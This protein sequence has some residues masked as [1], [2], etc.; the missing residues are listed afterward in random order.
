[1]ITAAGGTLIG[2]D[3]VKL[4]LPADALVADREFQISKNATGAPNLPEGSGGTD[5]D[6]RDHSAYT[7][8]ATP[9][10]LERWWV[11]RAR[12]TAGLSRKTL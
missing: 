8:D 4:I 5:S 9:L 7:R 6:L 11:M 10:C 1:V 2:P 3:S 12:I